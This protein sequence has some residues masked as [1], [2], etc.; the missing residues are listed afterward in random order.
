MARR[1]NRGHGETHWDW[2]MMKSWGGRKDGDAKE[3]RGSQS[4]QLSLSVRQQT[5][6]GAVVSCGVVS[7]GDSCTKPGWLQ[8][9]R[10]AMCFQRLPPGTSMLASEAA[11]L[12]KS[13]CK[14]SSDT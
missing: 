1:K 12:S 6:R 5:K 3:E 11:K 10:E 13:P 8:P 4:C 9:Q 14:V 2:W 7:C